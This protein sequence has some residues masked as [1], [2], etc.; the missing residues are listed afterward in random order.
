MKTDAGKNNHTRTRVGLRSGRM[1][2]FAQACGGVV[3]R[4]CDKDDGV[5]VLSQDSR[6]CWS[7][8]SDPPLL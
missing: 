1:K 3:A 4:T 7:W 2:R 8:P 6:C 5:E